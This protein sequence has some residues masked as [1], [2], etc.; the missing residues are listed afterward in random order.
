MQDTFINGWTTGSIQQKAAHKS[1]STDKANKHPMIVKQTKQETDKQCIFLFQGH[2][3]FLFPKLCAP[4]Q[5]SE[6][7]DDIITNSKALTE[8]SQKV[9]QQ[10]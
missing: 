9:G 7:D 6:S 3:L 1:L 4:D 8:L 10:W 2:N 5:K